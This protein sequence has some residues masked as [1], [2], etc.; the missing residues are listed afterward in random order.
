M[1]LRLSNE[2]VMK[3]GDVAPPPIDIGACC[4]CIQLRA[5]AQACPRRCLWLWLRRAFTS[6]I[7]I[8]WIVTLLICSK[9]TIKRSEDKTPLYTAGVKENPMG[10]NWQPWL[11]LG[12]GGGNRAHARARG[13]WGQAT[14]VLFSDC[15]VAIQLLAHSP[16]LVPWH[17]LSVGCCSSYL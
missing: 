4:S 2:V 13:G 1:R 10:N 9:R 11:S 12:S 6:N 17:P 14:M 15:S 8:R 16:L 5:G 3:I 7:P